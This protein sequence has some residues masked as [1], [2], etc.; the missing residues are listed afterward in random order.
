[1]AS[2]PEGR[3]TAP[4]WDGQYAAWTAAQAIRQND[5]IKRTIIRATRNAVRKGDVLD[6]ADAWAWVERAVF[7]NERRWF[8]A[9]VF[10]HASAPRR[11]A[12]WLLHAGVLESDP[13]RNRWLIEP[14]VGVLGAS[15]VLE[16]LL[17]YLRDGSFKEKAGAASAAYWVRPSEADTSYPEVARAFRDEMLQ[18]FVACADLTVQ[19]RIVPML[20][21]APESYS[22]GVSELLPAA[23]AKARES[24]DD[25]VRHRIAVQ[26]GEEHQF[27]ALPLAEKR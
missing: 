4:T 12:E 2:E 21:M 9:A 17:T 25:Y 27:R 15:R 26:L 18:Q 19:Q 16:R 8:V 20:S 13:S 11:V 24:D 14:A 23:I 3:D 22:A 6:H 10:G 5:K 7:D 1:M